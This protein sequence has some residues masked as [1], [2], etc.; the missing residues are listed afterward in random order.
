[1]V[2]KIKISSEEAGYLT[3]LLRQRYNKNSKITMSTLLLLAANEATKRETQE[4]F[5]VDKL[6]EV[7]GKTV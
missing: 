4:Q 3:Y 2:I 1:M 5:S 6:E 7:W